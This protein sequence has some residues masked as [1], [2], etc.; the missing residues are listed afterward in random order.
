MPIPATLPLL[1]AGLVVW[2]WLPGFAVAARTPDT[3]TV[4][5]SNM[6]SRSYA[7]A[8][9]YFVADGVDSR[10]CTICVHVDSA[11]R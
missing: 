8:L 4:F 2:D 9:H 5:E 11:V 10:C 7:A 1:L 3:A 6:G